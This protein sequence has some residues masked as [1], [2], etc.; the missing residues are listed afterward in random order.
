MAAFL[1]SVFVFAAG[2]A[3]YGFHSPRGRNQYV[4]GGTINIAWSSVDDFVDIYLTKQSFLN[5][6]QPVEPITIADNITNTGS[7]QWIVPNDLGAAFTGNVRMY[8]INSRTKS[9]SFQ[10]EYFHI[11][12][13]EQDYADLST[14]SWANFTAPTGA[15]KTFF[16][17]KRTVGI[18]WDTDVEFVNLT[19][20]T[21]VNA[22]W[23]II[24]EN[25]ST[26]IDGF[27]R[28]PGIAVWS[29]QD[30]TTYS[31]PF[32]FRLMSNDTLA[33]DT[34]VES[35]AFYTAPENY[36]DYFDFTEHLDDEGFLFPTQALA[37]SLRVNDTVVFTWRKPMPDDYDI[38]L[39]VWAE[40]YKTGWITGPEDENIVRTPTNISY[41]I[42]TYDIQDRFRQPYTFNLLSRNSRSGYPGYRAIMRTE[43]LTFGDPAGSAEKT[44]IAPAVAFETSTSTSGTPPGANTTSLDSSAAN[45][46]DDSGVSRSELKLYVGLG[47]GLGVAAILL[48]MGIGFFC[49]KKRRG[50]KNDTH[51]G[52][53]P[54]RK[55]ELDAKGAR[56]E[57]S[58]EGQ[59]ALPTAELPSQGTAHYREE[60]DRHGNVHELPGQTTSG[61]TL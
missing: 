36:P 15:P 58:E 18:S 57:L 2:V 48:F 27:T 20:C 12:Y 7:F 54:W 13:G 25:M 24:G 41:R 44:W 29:V 37:P 21:D 33:G 46:S 51:E 43:P 50:A 6:K 47:V 35:N 30:I 9:R 11:Y 39:G 3:S 42:E 56:H 28:N 53:E 5:P 45:G 26:T 14:P 1:V 32:R 55:S 40:N 52:S 38:E 59:L 16:T 31:L 60:H 61:R 4:V 8:L 19:Y 34:Y 17:D 49:W 10:T 22:P 23:P